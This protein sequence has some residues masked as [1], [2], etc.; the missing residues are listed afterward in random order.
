MSD[1]KHTPGPDARL[2]EAGPHTTLENDNADKGMPSVGDILLYQ[3]PPVDGLAFSRPLLVTSVHSQDQRV[4][5][6]VF[7]DQLDSQPDFNV[8]DV[9]FGQAGQSNT[10]HWPVRGYTGRSDAP[11]LTPVDSVE[12]TQEVRETRPLSLRVEL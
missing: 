10:W 1:P 7:T 2:P 8:H 11:G 9:A 12:H 6:R 4:S 3:L 5:G